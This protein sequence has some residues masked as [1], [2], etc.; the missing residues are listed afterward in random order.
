MATEESKAQ[1]VELMDNIGV[2][3]DE[4]EKTYNLKWTRVHDRSIQVA[5]KDGR[6]VSLVLYGPR[7]K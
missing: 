1:D 4:L 7:G 3:L 5:F 6:V 2:F